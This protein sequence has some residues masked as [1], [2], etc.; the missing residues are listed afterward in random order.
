[1]SPRCIPRGTTVTRQTRA[2]PRLGPTPIGHVR[3]QRRSLTLWRAAK[4]SIIQTGGRHDDDEASRQ[5]SG[6]DQ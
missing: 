5:A 4:M 6:E 1:M 3:G 2:Q